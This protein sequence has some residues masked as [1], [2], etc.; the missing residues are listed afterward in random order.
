M[1][2]PAGVLRGSGGPPGCAAS[3]QPLNWPR[4]TGAE[5]GRVTMPVPVP[6]HLDDHKRQLALQQE[7]EALAD[8]VGGVPGLGSGKGGGWPRSDPAADTLQPDVADGHVSE[9]LRQTKPPGR[10]A[11]RG[12]A[13]PGAQ[14][15][16]AQRLPTLAGSDL[17]PRARMSP[18]LLDE[19][20]D[21]DGFL[22]AEGQRA[23]QAVE[24]P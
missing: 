16:P 4:G 8:A 14:A 10:V 23:G 24:L 19:P 13:P 18:H 17:C 22:L 12:E 7:E 11:P 2:L 1:I 5:G 9:R 20:D 15:G 21:A 3:S 6:P